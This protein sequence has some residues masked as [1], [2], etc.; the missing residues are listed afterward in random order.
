[1]PRQLR[2]EYPGAIYHIMN[3]GDR[4]EPIFRDDWDRKRFV[5]TLGEACEKTDWQ[6]H[7]YCL[8]LNHFH[9]VI[10][11]P[12][13][14]LVAGMKWFLTTYTIRFNLRHK[15]VGHLFSGRY[16]SLIVDGSGN[17]YLRTVCDYVHLNPIRAKLLSAEQKLRDYCWSSWPDYLRA[18]GKRPSWLRVDRL[19]GELNI[20]KDSPA[21]RQQLERYLEA[22][23]QQEGAE[24]LN[25]IRRGW[26]LG[27]EQ[28][29]Q[30]LLEHAHTRS[31]ENH[32]A[33]T[34]HET[35]EHKA[36]RI[37]SEELE[38]LGWREGDLAAHAKGDCRKVALAKRLR[39]ETS[40]TLKWISEAL[41]MGSW[42]HVAS[43]LSR[44]GKRNEPAESAP[45]QVCVKAKD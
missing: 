5:D 2:I 17:G 22:R 27:D 10:E 7:S 25:A 19:L 33:Q 31:N 34:R 14:N 43:Q 35:A 13:G 20:P 36:Q 44:L 32:L 42:T 24:D 12:S 40:V 16:K 28:F 38:M 4:R 11:T 30:E 26:C 18:P 39:S 37:I 45:G 3:R 21:G 29:R 23:R 8:M 1:M 9:L 15:I 41:R 6:V